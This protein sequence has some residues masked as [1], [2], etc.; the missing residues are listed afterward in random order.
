[1]L[2][3]SISRFSFILNYLHTIIPIF[4]TWILCPTST[5]LYHHCFVPLSSKKNKQPTKLQGTAIEE[6]RS[7][8]WPWNQKDSTHRKWFIPLKMVE[9]NGSLSM[10]QNFCYVAILKIFKWELSMMLQKNNDHWVNYWVKMIA[11]ILNKTAACGTWFKVS[12][13]QLVEVKRVPMD[14]PFLLTP[15]CF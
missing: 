7:P 15:A 8:S 14:L 4:F 1:M 3:R 13:Q 5:F 2:H 9:Q 10:R 11:T 12:T 6:K